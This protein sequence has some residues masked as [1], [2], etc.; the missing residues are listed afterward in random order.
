MAFGGPALV[1]PFDKSGPDLAGWAGKAATTASKGTIRK[2]SL[3]MRIIKIPLTTFYKTKSL[4]NY[5][6]NQ[7]AKS[8]PT[9]DFQWDTWGK[10]GI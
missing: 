9:A 6:N 1:D 7:K 4:L 8:V 10:S 5:L 3:F 2:T